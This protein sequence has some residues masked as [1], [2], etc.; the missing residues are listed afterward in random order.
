MKRLI[1]LDILLALII[2]GANAAQAAA[3]QFQKALQRYDL[4]FLMRQM[5]VGETLVWK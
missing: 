5:Q 3:E 2:L 4:E 1:L